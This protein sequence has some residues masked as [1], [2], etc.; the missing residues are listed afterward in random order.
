MSETVEYLAGRL[1]EILP[2]YIKGLG[3]ELVGL[4]DDLSCLNKSNPEDGF[5]PL[6]HAN[7]MLSLV[8]KGYEAIDTDKLVNNPETLCLKEVPKLIEELSEKMGCINKGDM[9]D[10]TISSARS[11]SLEIILKGQELRNYINDYTNKLTKLGQTDLA[12]KYR[13]KSTHSFSSGIF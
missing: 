1:D 3:S 13:H 7:E 12:W 5:D 10:D 6:S 11:I 4:S 2:F 9:S 8:V